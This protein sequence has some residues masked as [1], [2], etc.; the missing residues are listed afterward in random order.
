MYDI[1][2]DPFEWTNLAAIDESSLLLA[3]FRKSSPQNFAK[4][5]EPSVESLIRLAWHPAMEGTTPSSRPDGNPFQVHFENR[6][7]SDVDLFWMVREGK[8]V[9]YGQIATGQR[10]SQQSRPGAVWMLQDA[11]LKTPL[12]YFVVGDRAAQAIIPAE[13]SAR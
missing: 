9:S 1:R 2:T 4:Q 7:K 10:K 12:G 13:A 11:E 3:E 5:I 6:R 8:P